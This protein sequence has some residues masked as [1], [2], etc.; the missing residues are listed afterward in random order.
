MSND[1]I[2]TINLSKKRDEN[3]DD[4]KSLNQLSK[5]GTILLVTPLI[6]FLKNHK[7]E[8][9]GDDTHNI[10]VVTKWVDSTEKFSIYKAELIQIYLDFLDDPMNILNVAESSQELHDLWLEIINL[11]Y[12]D[13]SYI[14]DVVKR[15]DI[16]YSN[17]YWRRAL[18][19]DI[20]FSPLQVLS[21]GYNYFER[22][23]NYRL[24]LPPDYRAKLA[25]LF[26][27]PDAVRPIRCEKL[28]DKNFTVDNF[29][30]SLENDLTY[31]SGYSLTGSPL[32]ANRIIT[33]G[34]LKSMKKSWDVKEFS[35]SGQEY[36][37]DR[38]EMLVN[39]FFTQ[40]SKYIANFS[41]EHLAKFVADTYPSL[42]AGNTFN[43]LLPEYKGL[44]KSWTEGNY[45]KYVCS[46]V[47]NI[48]AS[49]GKEW[50]SLEN[51]R[52]RLL[53][54]PPQN[55]LKFLSYP[56]L[57][58][59]EKISRCN[60]KE[61]DGSEWT[62]YEFYTPKWFEQIDLRFAVHWIEMLCAVGVVEIAREKPDI[63]P[64]KEVMGGIRYIRLTPLGLWLFGY[65]ERYIPT[66][67]EDAS[68]HI[69][70]DEQNC[71]LTILT[72]SCPYTLF[73]KEICRP[74]GGKRFKITIESI[75]NGCKNERDLK[76]RITTIRK[77][78][79]VKN[80]PRLAALLEET[81]QRGDC[82]D[83]DPEEYILMKLR[84]EVPGLMEFI[85]TNEKIRKHIV[86]TE[87]PIILVKRHR[88]RDVLLICQEHGYLL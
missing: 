13:S 50:M 54:S 33:P 42:L 16:I 74:I 17:A 26:I 28:P 81:E 35:I 31:L 55:W 86:L 15:K 12:I 9:T 56:T 61:K 53:C 66:T 88:L 40:P 75:M 76:K 60:L 24:S 25:I 65:T 82:I 71:I 77:I 79:D 18:Y 7:H 3:S 8:I 63:I 38:A 6:D 11:P 32:N 5:D 22:Q 23:K 27:G 80:S 39:T 67:V 49:A 10:D 2:I 78:L 14:Q 62:L 48:V 43:A 73:L 46:A 52:L 57:F 68:C 84:P 29:E 37:A 34:K 1:N 47:N 64:V 69:D 51:F 44:S 19:P 59:S 58:S 4:F 36:Q 70:F 87:Q 45:A 83:T 21:D 30:P 85:T 41:A 20:L 72:D